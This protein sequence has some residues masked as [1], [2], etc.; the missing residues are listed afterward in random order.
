MISA[1]DRDKA[2]ELIDEAVEHGARLFMACKE[3]NIHKRTY[4]RWKKNREDNGTTADLR[5]TAERPEPAN[6]LSPDERQAILDTV[7][8]EEYKDLPPCEIVPDLADKGIYI[9]SESTM[10]RILREEKQLAH[11]GR[12][13]AP[14]KRHITTH[15]AT[16]KNQVWMWDITYL[17]GPVKGQFYYLYMFSDLYTRDIAGW[18]VYETED[19]EHASQTI[20][21]LCLKHHIK[22]TDLLILHSDNG[23][24]M[25]G[26][27]MLETLYKLGITPSNSR[28]RVSNDNAYAESLFKT[29]KYRPNYQPKGFKTLQ[30]AREWVSG[31]VRWYRY[32]HHHSGICY[33]TPAQVSE[34]NAQEILAE[35]IKVY[36]AAKAKHPE[37]WNGRKIRNWSLSEVVYLNPEK[38]ASEKNIQAET[39]NKSISQD[40]KEVPTDVA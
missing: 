24:P 18:E 30:A 2:I 33:L 38:P 11:R 6:R 27:T 32:E 23:S 7:N 26:A 15:E 12:A 34:G 8:S 40:S 29:L 25:K 3:L 4:Q 1:S 35:R 14:V 16:A 20:R 13:E 10:Y 21:R 5:P 31:F 37:R 19:M 9:G 22:S 39:K 17:N 36:E 28:P